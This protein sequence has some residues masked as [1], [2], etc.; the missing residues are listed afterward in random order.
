MNYTTKVNKYATVRLHKLPPEAQPLFAQRKKFPAGCTL[1]CN[2]GPLGGLYYSQRMASD[3]LRDD[4]I[5][6]DA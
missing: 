4:N 1:P 2:F 6:K 3:Q 5:G